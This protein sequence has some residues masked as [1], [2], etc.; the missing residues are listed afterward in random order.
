[1]GG[2]GICPACDCGTYDGHALA[3]HNSKLSTELAALRSL[4][5]EVTLLIKA[6]AS[7]YSQRQRVL[8]VPKAVALL[9]RLEDAAKE[10][11]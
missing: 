3:W 1:M 11:P 2:P 8:M 9:P 7:G 5:R 6:I 4:M 10:K